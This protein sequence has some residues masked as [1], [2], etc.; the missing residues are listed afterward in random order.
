MSRIHFLEKYAKADRHYDTKAE[1]DKA[2][3]GSNND[4]YWISLHPSLTHEHMLH[5]AHSDDD[6]IRGRIARRPDVPIGILYNLYHGDDSEYVRSVA[7]KNPITKT[8]EFRLY[9]PSNI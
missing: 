7:Y 8:N 3:H 1:L 4:Q 6:T 5:L 2:V 9:S